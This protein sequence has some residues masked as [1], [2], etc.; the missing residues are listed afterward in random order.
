LKLILLRHA[1]SSWDDFTLDDHDRPLNDRGRAAART[2]GA[3][4]REKNH[5]PDRV[6]CSTATRAQETLEL[7][8]EAAQISPQAD[9]VEG[10]Y[11]ASPDRVLRQ[12]QKSKPG[13]LMLVG[14]NPG[15]ADLAAMLARQAPAHREFSR[16]PTASTF[17]VEF[18]ITEW[19]DA[20]FGHGSAIDFVTP[21]ELTE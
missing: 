9:M 14:H 5:L 16:F 10:L 6:A 13:T 1:K 12:I 2:I 4:L 15:F 20:K 11:H 8:C 17:V 7:V 18:P 19:C 3:W 21:R